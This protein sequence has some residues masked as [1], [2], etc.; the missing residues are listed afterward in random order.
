VIPQDQI[1][2]NC[3]ILQKI[4]NIPAIA[5]LRDNA[6]LIIIVVP[7]FLHCLVLDTYAHG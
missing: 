7:Y 5:I 6:N 4:A 3:K 2:Q 1:L